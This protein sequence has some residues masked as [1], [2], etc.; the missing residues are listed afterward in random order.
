[1][2]TTSCAPTG[3]LGR[4]GREFSR[5]S[6]QRSDRRNRPMPRVRGELQVEATGGDSPE[7]TARG[8]AKGRPPE[9]LE[10]PPLRR[11]QPRR[12]E[13]AL[14]QPQAVEPVSAEPLVRRRHRCA[15]VAIGTQRLV[16]E[17]DAVRDQ[18]P[19]PQIQ[20]GA[21]PEMDVEETI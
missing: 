21:L 18:D 13:D 8:P 2:S 19:N 14:E 5:L 4:R 10:L 15:V 12:S 1:M 6:Q 9:P 7:L 3:R 20:V 17:A 16:D 11:L